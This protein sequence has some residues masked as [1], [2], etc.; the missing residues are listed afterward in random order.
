MD[1]PPEPDRIEDIRTFLALVGCGHAKL[2][3]CSPFHLREYAQGWATDKIP[4]SLCYRRIK[5]RCIVDSQLPALDCMIRRDWAAQIRS[6]RARPSETTSLPQRHAV[7][8]SID[9][10]VVSGKVSSL[11][12][13]EKAMDFLREKLGGGEVE[14]T[15]VEADARDA[16]VA[17]RTLDRARARL[18]VISR[19][20]GFGRNGKSW[21]SLPTTPTNA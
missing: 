15:V 21:L 14:A 10:I 2:G 20:T 3:T 11:K 18:G 12:P 8:S 1:Y 6:A 9:Q 4:L 13:L 7:E 17:I 19:R 5:G 16:G